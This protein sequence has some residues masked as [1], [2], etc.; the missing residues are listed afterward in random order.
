[1]EW[2]EVDPGRKKREIRPREA[3]RLGGGAKHSVTWRSPALPCG[4]G[5][6]RRGEGR[7]R[8]P[9]PRP[10]PSRGGREPG[11]G[12]GRSRRC[13]GAAGRGRRP[14]SA[15]RRRWIAVRL[16]PA[17]VEP[18]GRAVLGRA[19]PCGSTRPLPPERSC[20]ELTLEPS[21]THSDSTRTRE[22]GDRVLQLASPAAKKPVFVFE[23]WRNGRR[24]CSQLKPED[25][26]QGIKHCLPG[27]LFV[28]L[29]LFLLGAWCGIIYLFLLC[30]SISP[31]NVDS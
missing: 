28:S 10:T 8:R 19:A 15:R 4:P 11:A 16:G 29:A 14:R 1:M 5:P 17:R 3:A 24:R 7:V 21:P 31:S 2:E 30:G 20:W 27:T 12:R 25:N 26:H 18:A 13:L 22:E 9:P 23:V 6:A